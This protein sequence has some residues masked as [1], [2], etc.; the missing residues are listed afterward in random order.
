MTDTCNEEY[1]VGLETRNVFLDTEV[2]RSYR[3]NLN[4]KTMEVLGRYVEEGILVLHTTNVTLRE[5]SRQLGAMESELTN[6]ANK[7]AKDWA[8]WNIR[9]RFDHHRLP[10]PDL[11][12]EPS[13]PSRA[14]RDFEWTV[15]Y[16]WKGN[17]KEYLT[18]PTG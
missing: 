8:R 17:Y 13:Q 12:S 16:D 5:V 2:F 15:L 14:Y 3:H 18:N 6:R 1:P 11:L 7:I 9:Y 10:V 4:A